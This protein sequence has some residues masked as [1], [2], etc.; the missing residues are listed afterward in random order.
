MDL[1]AYEQLIERLDKVQDDLDLI[2]EKLEIN[3][4]DEDLDEVEVEEEVS[5]KIL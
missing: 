2:K 3:E 1:Y 5:D 4:E